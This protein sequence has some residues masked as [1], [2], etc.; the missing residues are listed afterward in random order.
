M[1][2]HIWL[3]LNLFQIYSFHVHIY[4]FDTSIICTHKYGWYLLDFWIH[5]LCAYDFLRIYTYI[6]A[7]TY[8]HT[9]G[10]MPNFQGLVAMSQ[11]YFIL[12]GINCLIILTVRDVSSTKI[13]WKIMS[14]SWRNVSNRPKK[15]AYLCMLH[16]CIVYIYIY[17]YMYIYIYVYVYIYMYMHIYVY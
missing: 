7:Y 13:G 17:I 14:L 8:L 10:R 16:R 1:H 2:K 9:Q 3:L 15:Y 12:C 6:Y 5:S 4:I 11:L